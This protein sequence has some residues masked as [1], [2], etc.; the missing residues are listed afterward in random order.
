MTD[1]SGTHQEPGGRF[2]LKK[3]PLIGRGH[4]SWQQNPFVGTKP[5]QGLLVILG[6]SSTA[7]I[8]RTSTTRCMRFRSS[9]D[10]RRTLVRRPRFL[11][12]ALGETARLPSQGAAIRTPV[13]AH[14]FHHPASRTGSW[15]STTTDGTRSCFRHRITPEDVHWA[16]DLLAG[17]QLGSSGPTRSAP[18][19]TSRPSPTGSF[20]G[21]SRR[22]PKGERVGLSPMRQSS[23]GATESSAG[24][25]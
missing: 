20:A 4:W 25:R 12:T 17:A 14:A 7:R 15:S 2:R 22:W 24:L 23:P 18:A 16:S 5:Y 19:A 11:G 9:D 8:S 13:R 1:A 3:E 6:D 21:S 10:E